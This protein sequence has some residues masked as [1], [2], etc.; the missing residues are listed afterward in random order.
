M[1]K[2]LNDEKAAIAA[3]EA[4]LAERKRRLAEREREIALEAI[5]KTGLLKLDTDRLGGIVANIRKLG[6]EEVEKRLAA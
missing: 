3:E 2:S 1:A 4:R 5:E 6:I